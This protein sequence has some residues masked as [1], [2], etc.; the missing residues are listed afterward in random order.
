[1]NENKKKDLI[2]G[3]FNRYDSDHLKPWVNSIKKSGFSGDC[4]AIIYGNENKSED[5]L[6][7]NGFI[8]RK[9]QDYSKSIV[10]DRFND[11]S[12]YLQ[13]VSEKYRYIIST[14]VGDVVFQTNPSIFLESRLVDKNILVGSECVLYK[15]ETWGRDNML[16]SYPEKA[17]SMMNKVI[18]NA[19]T[20]AVK[21]ETAVN[22]FK[23]IYNLSMTTEVSNPD[24]AAMNILIQS[25][26][27][28]ET[29]FSSLKDGWAIQCGT[30]ADPI[31]LMQ[32][33]HLLI[34][35]KF[36]FFDGICYNED[37]KKTCLVHQY[38]RVPNIYFSV[39]KNYE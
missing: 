17:I 29:Y 38:N 22:F 1:M 31:K 37:N 10:V 35:N 6:K 15:D 23:D 3:C 32:Y 2:I 25:K 33:G 21:S 11:M 16:S 9:V 30:V 5:Y 26:Y 27:F 20:I 8:I 12:S 14:D 39:R 13:S 18:Y 19:G 24:Q 36:A 7:N 28:N 34:E 4:L